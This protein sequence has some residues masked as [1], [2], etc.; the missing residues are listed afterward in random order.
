MNSWIFIGYVGSNRGIGYGLVKQFLEK[1]NAKVIATCRDPDGATLLH[2]L[3]QQHGEHR[4]LMFPL[5]VKNE[6]AFQEIHDALSSQGINT[7]DILIGNAG[8]SNPDHPHDSFL[9]CSPDEMLDIFRTNVI[10]N[11]KLLQTFTNM[12]CGSTLKLS[13]IMSSILGSKDHA[14]R[15]GGD[16]TSYRVSKSALNMLCVLYA[17]DPLIQ[18]SNVHMLILHPGSVKTDMGLTGGQEAQLELD[19]STTCILHCIECICAYKL[20]CLLHDSPDWIAEVEAIHF[21]ESLEGIEARSDLQ[22]LVDHV[23]QHHFVYAAWDGN[24][25]DW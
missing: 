5:D 9:T 16:I 22:A 10:G 17:C 23:T 7:I 25:L 15:S 14:A 2:E 18:A 20:R 19:Q 4:L 6:N 3:K 13:V 12:V 1:T 11:M 24:I 21:S 8:I